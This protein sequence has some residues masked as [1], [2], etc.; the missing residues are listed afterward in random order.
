MSTTGPDHRAMA[1]RIRRRLVQMT[2]QARSSH[3]GSGLSAADLLAVLYGGI[4][5]VDPA[6]PEWDERDRFVFSKGHAAAALYAALAERGFFPQERLETFYAD[7]SALM[8][9]VSAK[10][11]PG[12]DISTGSLGHGLSV[13]CGMALAG[14]RDE[15]AYRV[16]A[17][18]SDGECD[19]GSTWE[20]ALFAGHHRL[21]NLTAIIDYNKIQSLG[22]VDEVLDLAPLGDKWAAFGW[23]VREIDGHA[24]DE[25][26]RTLREVPLRP[27]R[28]SCI[29]AHT[30]KGKGVSFMEDDLLW[31]YRAPDGDEL[32]RA[33]RELERGG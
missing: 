3:V 22:R 4:L 26:D 28:P 7:G 17:L 29:I 24:V 10:D 30:V 9:H 8:G 33:L 16:F 27:D 32:A 5:R 14:R 18:L 19:E 20:A 12:V 25:I 13:A 15:R 31:H 2:H 11:V 1:L 21:S 6:R 23:S